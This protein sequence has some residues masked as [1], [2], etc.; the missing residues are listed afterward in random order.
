MGPRVVGSKLKSLYCRRLACSQ[1]RRPIIGHEVA[2]DIRVS[3]CQP[4][5][6][7][8]IVGVNRYCSPEMMQGFMLSV[9]EK[10][11]I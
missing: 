7:V 4:S 11:T 9:G 5:E 3:S 2:N 1:M 6:S 10:A 8:S